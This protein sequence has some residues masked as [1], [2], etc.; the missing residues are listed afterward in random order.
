M[1]ENTG[2]TETAEFSL[3]TAS[4]GLIDIDNEQGINGFPTPKILEYDNQTWLISG[5]ELGRIQVF[6]MPENP[7]ANAESEWTEWTNNWNGYQEGLFSAPA[8]AD[9]DNDGIPDLVVGGRDGGL[10]LWRGGA[11]DAIRVCSPLVDG[12]DNFP[13]PT[14]AEWRPAPNP[15]SAGSPLKV[16]SSKL[17]ILDVTGREIACLKAQA[18]S[19]KIPLDLPSGTYL[20]RPEGTQNATG[21]S[22]NW[23]SAR[24]LV[25]VADR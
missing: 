13:N 8:A 19:V 20:I 11:E 9:L 7:L 24:R 21:A 1:F 22:P 3:V 6:S 4:A 25:V 23:K 16:P 10:T 14:A 15:I 2:S 5:N 17:V 12:I 18:G